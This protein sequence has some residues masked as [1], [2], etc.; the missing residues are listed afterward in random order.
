MRIDLHTHS[1]RSD[2]TDTPRELV[3]RA[4]AEGIDVLG[5]TDHECAQAV[6]WVVPSGSTSGAEALR[7]F[8]A[9]GTRWA[10]VLGRLIVNRVTRPVTGSV[11]AVVARNRHRLGSPSCGVE[12]VGSTRHTG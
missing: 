10:A 11:Y 1:N 3:Q 7:D 9:T 8:A 6:Q 2:G 12:P 5:L 4:A